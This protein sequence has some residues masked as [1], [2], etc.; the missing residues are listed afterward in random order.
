MP[1]TLTNDA[2]AQMIEDAPRFGYVAKGVKYT[3][4]TT[5]AL[6][7]V[8]WE[9]LAARAECDAILTSRDDVCKQLAF[10]RDERDAAVAA[11]RERCARVAARACRLCS[12]RDVCDYGDVVAAA[13]R[14]GE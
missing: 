4:V 3:T 2:I 8:L 13:I 11:E 10:E 12:N 14:R 1:D 5:D 9:L 6:T 7:L